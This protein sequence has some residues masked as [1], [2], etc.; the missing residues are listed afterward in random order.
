[1]INKIQKFYNTLKD[2]GDLSHFIHRRR[3]LTIIDI[4]KDYSFVVACD[5]NAS[6]GNK[7]NDYVKKDPFEVGQSVTKVPLMEVL[8]VGALPFVIIN[9]LCVEF[10]PTGKQIL[11]GIKFELR[12]LGLD[13][14]LVVNGSCEKNMLTTQTGVGVTVLAIVYKKSLKI[15]ISKPGDLIV[16]I[17]IPKS[18]P[19]RPYN[20]G[21]YEIAD[22]LTVKKLRCLYYINEILPVGSN[23]VLYEMGILANECGCGLSVVESNVDLKFSSGASTSVIVTIPPQYYKTLK[24]EIT[25][26]VNQVGY[27][28]VK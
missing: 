21:D 10:E 23:G 3:D 16:C 22:P 8:A 27:L 15:G 26:P 1:M 25:K 5:S 17:G 20:E 19:E 9:N 24:K 4:V 18:A 13:P 14:N 7:K 11:E 12:N 2:E 6:L 28:C